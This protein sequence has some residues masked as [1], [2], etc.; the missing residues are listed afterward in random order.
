MNLRC[1]KSDSLAV[2]FIPATAKTLNICSISEQVEQI[3]SAYGL[4]IDCQYANEQSCPDGHLEQE[5]TPEKYVYVVYDLEDYSLHNILRL[6][7][8]QPSKKIHLGTFNPQRNIIVTGNSTY[9]L[10]NQP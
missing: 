6:F 2:S 8:K 4:D 7:E 3:A 10:L 9:T 1:A 5:K